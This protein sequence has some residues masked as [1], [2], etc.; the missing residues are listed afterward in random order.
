M[1]D[2][3]RSPTDPSVQALAQLPQNYVAPQALEAG[4][5]WWIRRMDWE[6]IRRAVSR[7]NAGD[8]FNASWTSFL[9]G[10]A[11]ASLVAFVTL[12]VTLASDSNS[13]GTVQAIFGAGAIFAGLCTWLIYT[14]E[15]RARK[16]RSD[17]LDALHEELD[18]AERYMKK[19]TEGQ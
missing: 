11:A 1:T 8:T 10:L 18:A 9:G 7:C 6:A 13:H 14:V 19:I 16:R 17:F 15:S 2:T 3:P 4:E 5:L 12:H